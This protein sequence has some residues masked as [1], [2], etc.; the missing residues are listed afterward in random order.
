MRT[1][2]IFARGSCR[3]L[4][5][6]ALVGV[7]F[8]LGAGQ[9]FAQ[10]T[11]STQTF[12]PGTNT[13]TLTASELVFGSPPGSAFTV[14]VTPLG[15]TAAGNVVTAVSPISQVSPS[16]R[17]ML[18]VTTA[19]QT[20]SAVTLTYA[21]AAPATPTNQIRAA[22]NTA[23]V[24]AVITSAVT[25]GEADQVPSIDQVGDM[26]LILGDRIT[27][28][29]L[30]EANRGN[31]PFTYT[32]NLSATTATG[33]ESGTTNPIN[34]VAPG[35]GS[36]HGL[37]FLANPPTLL[38]T[39]RVPGEYTLTYSVADSSTTGNSQTVPQTFKITVSAAPPPTTTG[40]LGE[41]VKTALVG[42]S[43]VKKTIGGTERNHV[44]EGAR[45]LQLEVTAEWEVDELRTIYGSS[46]TVDP[47]EVTVA[48]MKGS[49]STGEDWISWI[50]DRQDVNF[51]D[52]R[53]LL[54]HTVEI[55]LP[56]KP[57]DGDRGSDTLESIGKLDVDI[58]HDDREAENDMFYIMVTGSSD[59]NVRVGRAGDK[60]TLDTV[61][62]DDDPQSVTVRKGTS[63]GP[64]TVYESDEE[65][66]FTVAADPPRNQLPLEVD[67]DM[68]DLEGTTVRAAKISVDTRRLE[69]NADGDGSGNSATVTV[70]LPDSDGDR[71]NNDYQ[72]QATVNPYSLASGTDT[73]VEPTSHMIKVL[74]V[75]KLPDVSV[76]SATDTVAEGEKVELV[77]MIDR[78]P[79][80][81]TV[82]PEKLEYTQEEVT[83]MLAMGAGSTAD[84]SD[85]SIMPASVTFPKRERGSYTASM[86]VEV[87]ALP[88][89]ELDDME[90]LVLDAEVAGADVANGTEKDMSPGVLT[91]TI[92]E[93]TVKQ[94]EPKTEAAVMKAFD[95]AKAAG[96]GDEGLN[97]DESFSVKVSDLF[98]VADGYAADY[99]VSATGDAVTARESN[100]TVEISAEEVGESTITITAKAAPSMSSAVMTRQTAADSAEVDYVVQ[101]VN[102]KLMVTVAAE[103]MTIKEGETSM[104]TATVAD[105]SVHA[106]DGMVKIDLA[107]TG[108]A[109]LSADSITIAAG[110]MMGSVTLTATEDDDY[111]DETVTVIAS[112]SGITGQQSLTIMVTDPDEATPT[113]RAK[114]DAA[115]KIAAAIAKAAGGAEWMVG[116]MV[117]EVEMDGL[118]DLDEGVTATYQGTSSDADVVKAITTGNTLML[119]PMG[120]GMATITVTGA[121]NAGGSEAAMVMHDAT[122]VLANLTMMVTVEPMTVEEGGMVTITAKASRM[123]AMSDGMVKV[124]LSVVG[125][126]TLSAEMI[127]I[128]ADSDTGTA[129]LT[130]TDD[131]M[132]EP[133]GETVTLIASGAGIDGNMSFDIMVTD[134]D[135]AAVDVTF[136]LSGPEDMNLPEGKSAT[137]TATASAAVEEDTEIMIMRDGTSTAGAD[138]YTAESIMIMA[139]ET[140][141]TTMVMAVEDNEPDSGSGSPEM[142]TLYGMVGNMQTNSVS[143]YLWDAAVPALPVIAQLLLAAF[144]AI[145]GYRR[146][147]RR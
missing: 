14:M 35:S 61:I 69:L 113:V 79:A 48:I 83:V 46:D 55:K 24:L 77:V 74:D 23:E 8:A 110:D 10:P 13:I 135:A 29:E 93:G 141:G 144:L 132:H 105:R 112:G 108:P 6:M 73:T 115:E 138:D 124:N 91:L 101:V 1:G 4:K 133:D 86:T 45:D 71:E 129:T 28:K 58:L 15:G 5:W 75:H 123:I 39:A 85:Y 41:I 131:E 104:I 146:Y 147:L 97:P 19:I 68:L 30:P 53:G 119:T 38:G 125:D 118:F 22:A 12:E 18:T 102:K 134:N 103:P 100:G 78:N 140:T 121:D 66:E 99:D 59:V 27:A 76:S 64:S 33:V 136:T 94:V 34:T 49:G 139:G 81:T 80:N 111:D 50:D 88:D 7:V 109:T 44:P 114:T 21:P 25:V 143:F 117:A 87:Q 17:I 82:G 65:I 95:D 16:N 2:A 67:L 11:I 37:R 107:V 116:G 40:N 70:H 96:A 20:G 63:N 126:A 145:G 122:V 56:K 72:L 98:T 127:E 43:L 130:S 60:K 137:L 26:S 9:A 142:L 36:D 42:N 51:P 3:A 31:Q 106:D 52:N 54:E 32:L 47:V 90:M 120:A 89:E 128:K 84:A 57:K 62:E 92:E